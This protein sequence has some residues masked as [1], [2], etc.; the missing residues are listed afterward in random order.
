MVEVAR[1]TVGKIMTFIECRLLTNWFSHSGHL[2]LPERQESPRVQKNYFCS[3]NHDA[4]AAAGI[5]G[6][7]VSSAGANGAVI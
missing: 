5:A 7:D 4:L 6:D 1:G 2:S 3:A